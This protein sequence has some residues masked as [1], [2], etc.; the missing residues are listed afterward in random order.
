MPVRAAVNR[1]CH[2]GFLVAV[3]RKGIYVNTLRIDDVREIYEMLEALD[4]MAV[5]L[6]AGRS[7]AA[8]VDPL[9]ELVAAEERAVLDADFEAEYR[10]NRLFHERLAGLLE[11]CGLLT[12]SICARSRSDAPPV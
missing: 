12:P 11:T 9:D 5:R 7:W 8:D 4:G 10:A 1:L 2:D 6:A 3:A